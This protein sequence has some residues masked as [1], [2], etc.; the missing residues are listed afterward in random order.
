MQVAN[1]LGSPTVPVVVWTLWLGKP[2]KGAR[3]QAFRDIEASVGVPVILV[4][5][6]CL[7][8][9][10]AQSSSKDC[11]SH[12]CS[13]IICSLVHLLFALLFH[14]DHTHLS[15]FFYYTALRKNIFSRTNHMHYRMLRPHSDALLSYMPPLT[16]FRHNNMIS[17]LRCV[18]RRRTFR[19]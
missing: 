16:S 12:A 15:A 17:S 5:V 2:M 7:S 11:T 6:T 3:L 14:M 8:F 4:Q 1:L 18:S 9:L 10:F 19:E 13:C